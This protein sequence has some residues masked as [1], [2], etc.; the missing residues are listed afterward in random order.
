MLT[1]TLGCRGCRRP[2][3]ESR[4]GEWGLGVAAPGSYIEKA[5]LSLR[6]AG[7]EDM[8]R[9]EWSPP[10]PPPPPLLTPPCQC[11]GLPPPPPPKP[12]APPPPMTWPPRNAL[13]SV[14]IREIY[15]ER[16]GRGR[17]VTLMCQR[18]HGQVS[19]YT[20]TVQGASFS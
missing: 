10:L 17:R 6:W 19:T 9:L 8:A 4:P 1:L 15:G 3:R 7:D 12:P 13:F 14:C 20:G 18:S 16:W 11:A 2:V 5:C